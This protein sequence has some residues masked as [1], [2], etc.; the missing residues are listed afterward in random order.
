MTRICVIGNSH[1]G[2][3][4]TAW[5]RMAADWPGVAVTFFAARARATEGLEPKDG[6]LVPKSADLAAQM[7]FTSGGPALIDPADHDL[8]LVYAGYEHIRVAS[9]FDQVSRAL[10]EKT[11]LERAEESLL[12][13]HVR[14][15]RAITDKPVYAAL[16]PVPLA[17]RDKP[18]A[19]MPPHAQVVALLQAGVFD[20]LGATLIAQPEATLAEGRTTLG[21]FATGSEK[22]ATIKDQAPGRHGGGDSVHMN[23]EYGRLWLTAFLQRLHQREAASDKGKGRGLLGAMRRLI[24]RG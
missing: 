24:G 20:A 16:T 6:K 9:A 21:R 8:F 12:L 22:L 14:N 23:V 3:I 19:T 15:L 2:A 17:P 18:P 10:A 13:H 4:K 5:D 7:A 11:L 1:T